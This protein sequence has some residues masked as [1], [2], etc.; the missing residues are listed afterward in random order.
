MLNKDVQI[1][2]VKLCHFSYAR[3]WARSRGAQEQVNAQGGILI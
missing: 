1:D 2:Y 3:P